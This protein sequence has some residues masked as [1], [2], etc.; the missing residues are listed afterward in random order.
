MHFGV[1]LPDRDAVLALRETGW[2]RRAS[3]FVEEWDEPEYVSIKCHD[4]D[5]YILEASWEP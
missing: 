3:S 4:P 5:G 1:S 2:P